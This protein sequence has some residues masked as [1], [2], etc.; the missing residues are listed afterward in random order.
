MLNPSWPTSG[1]SATR[2]EL[3][4]QPLLTRVNLFRGIRT[5]AASECPAQNYTDCRRRSVYVT[6]I[7]TCY[8]FLFPLH[9]YVRHFS[10]EQLARLGTFHAAKTEVEGCLRW[11]TNES[12]GNRS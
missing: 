10:S 8:T 11:H 3:S 5:F 2:N 6:Y 4:D 1:S 7:L 12:G 9:F